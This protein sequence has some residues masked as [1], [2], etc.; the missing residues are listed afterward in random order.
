MNSSANIFRVATLAIAMCLG[1]A[2]GV[3][4][5][6]VIFNVSGLFSNGASMSGTM[7][8]DTTAGVVDAWNIIL[9]SPI[10]E[11]FTSII[12]QASFPVSGIYFVSN[13]F[14]P[15]RLDLL[16]DS[17]SLV[18]YSGGL[19]NS[20]THLANGTF[21]SSWVD[22]DTGVAANLVNGQLTRAITAV[23]EPASL[24]LLGLGLA[25]LGFSRRKQE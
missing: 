4:K 3:A 15:D 20:T 8:I 17:S 13:N 1:S 23:P 12:F 21:F 18:G 25:G 6:A 22:L 19:L 16:I 2:A 24:A 9:S 10:S 11:V 5:A 7:A 14:S